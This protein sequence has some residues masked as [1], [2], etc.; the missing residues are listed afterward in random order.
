MAA[1]GV[2]EAHEGIILAVSSPNG[3]GLHGRVSIC[4]V[5]FLAFPTLDH[6]DGWVGDAGLT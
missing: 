4:R 5:S 3:A 1:R 6:S 2:C